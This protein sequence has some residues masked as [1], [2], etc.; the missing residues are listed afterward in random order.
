MTRFGKISRIWQN[1]KCLGI[2]WIAYLV[3]GNLLHQLWHF[4]AMGQI[5]KVVHGQRMNSI[6]DIWSHLCR[7][8]RTIAVSLPRSCWR[9][10]ISRCRG[11]GRSGTDDPSRS[12]TRPS[13]KRWTRWCSTNCPW[14]QKHYICIDSGMA[15]PQ[16]WSLLTKKSHKGVKQ[17]KPLLLFLCGKI[18]WFYLKVLRC[19]TWSIRN[20]VSVHWKL[21][22]IVLPQ[23][24]KYVLVC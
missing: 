12:W 21:S 23:F 10:W 13:A 16:N 4:Y 18:R 5:V 11:R 9:C 3:I 17:W 15:F 8:R 2:F 19:G 20:T 6:I 7:G 14:N 1:F 24:T 22:F